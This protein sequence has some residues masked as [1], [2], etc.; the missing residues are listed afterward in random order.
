MTDLM[1]DVRGLDVTFGST[2]VLHGVDV[3]LAKGRT[4]GVVGESG[5]GKSTLAK[6]LVGSVRPS[7]GHVDV[8]GV[9]LVNHEH[10]SMRRYR[11]RVQMIPQDPYSSLSPRR[12]IGQTLAEAINP[13]RSRVSDHRDLI[14]SWLERVGLTPDMMHRYPHEFSGGQRQR[15]AIARGLIIDPDFVIADEITSALDVSVQAQILELL[16]EIKESLGI[17]MMFIS[18]NLAVV[19]RVS[20]EVL[21]LYQGRVVEAGPVEEI[22]ANP[23]HW[24]TRRLL[25]A[26]PGSPGFSLAG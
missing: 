1:L 18:H 21:V 10:T 7:A 13:I 14:A 26:D 24:Y 22:Y 19:Q 4:V 2:T 12:T 17:T 20:D 15:I 8:D 6:V 23:Q 3:T 11:R 9:D 25:D 16:A 5:S